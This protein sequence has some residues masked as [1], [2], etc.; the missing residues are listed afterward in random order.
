[1]RQVHFFKAKTRL[2]INYLPFGQKESAHGVEDAPDKILTPDFLSSFNNYSLSTYDF[3]KPE[4]INAENYLKTV[5]EENLKFKNFILENLKENEIQVVIG[6][7][8]S[9]TYPSTLSDIEKYGSDIGFIHFDSHAD[10]NLYK[11][12]PT[13]NF[14][15][16]Y[17][18]IFIDKFDIDYFDKTVP[19][20]I[21]FDNF[22]FIGDLELDIEE[23]EFF[24]KN[25]LSNVKSDYI[26]ID[27]IKDF[28]KKFNHI[29]ISFDIDVFEKNLVSATGTP[30]KNG[31]GKENIFLILEIIKQNAKSFSLDLAEYNPKKIGATES[32]KISQEVLLKLL[33]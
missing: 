13:K 27:E 14:H 33:I 28:A 19:N 15:G 4:D 5:F 6:G 23:K 7:D 10:A 8:H 29:H 20:K 3:I 9:I 18:R 30:S 2:G 31:F 12:S 11:S 17:L 16:M 26:D 24:E 32:L 22:L 25:N 1:M 21:S